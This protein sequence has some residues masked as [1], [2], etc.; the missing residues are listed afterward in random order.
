MLPTL[1]IPDAKIINY[2]LVYQPKDDKSEYLA[3]YGYT[4]D[5]WQLLKE[6]II[7]ATQKSQNIE[8]TETDWGRR[9][10]IKIQ[11]YSI[12]KRI[13]KVI[14]IWQQD[15]NSDYAR[16]VTLFPDKTKEN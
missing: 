2:L 15:E 12:N 4:Q 3:N 10:K 8:I 16:F 11:W 6:D 14:T 7:K 9:F 13:I 5:N 1:I